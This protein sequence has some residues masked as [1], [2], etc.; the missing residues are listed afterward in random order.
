MLWHS[1]VHIIR[2]K[3]L[4]PGE[5]IRNYSFYFF[6]TQLLLLLLSSL[7]L[8]TSHLKL[9]STSNFLLIFIFF[10]TIALLACCYV[11]CTLNVHRRGSPLVVGVK[12]KAKLASD[13]FPVMY[14][15]GK[16]YSNIIY[17]IQ[18]IRTIIIIMGPFFR[19]TRK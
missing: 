1:K 9:S 7:R 19:S 10:T 11:M 16:L 17:T 15:K 18:V 5:I 12:S 4:W 3:L 13:R 8:K 6:S 2:V 14:S